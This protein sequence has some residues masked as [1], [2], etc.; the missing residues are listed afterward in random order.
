MSVEDRR[1]AI[2]AESRRLTLIAGLLGLAGFTVLGS[3]RVLGTNGP[4]L[5]DHTPGDLVLAL[6]YMSPY[7]LTLIVWRT[8]DPVARGGLLVALGLLSV[9]ASFSAFSLATLILIPASVTIFTAAAWSLR[10]VENRA[11]WVAPYFVAGLAGAA[12]IVFSFVATFVLDPDETRCWALVRLDSGGEQWERRGNVGGSPDR[13][14]IGPS[15]SEVTYSTCVSDIITISE[16]ARSAGLLAAAAIVII[17][18][19]HLGRRWP[20]G[21]EPGLVTLD[22]S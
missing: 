21:L 2:D 6:V 9:V 7:M 16:A 18:A 13:L 3:L 10:L 11:I 22:R 15:G 1:A 8:R 4:I 14:S 20:A 19:S 17:V 5:A 12:A